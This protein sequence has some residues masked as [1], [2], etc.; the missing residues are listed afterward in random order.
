MINKESLLCTSAAHIPIGLGNLGQRGTA[1]YVSLGGFWM[2]NHS[3]QTPWNGSE[4]FAFKHNMG[5]LR[6]LDTPKNDQ[7]N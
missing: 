6:K 7:R 2:G 4:F 1:R 5:L 3:S